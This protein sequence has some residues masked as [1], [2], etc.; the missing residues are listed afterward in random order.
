GEAE[1]KHTLRDALPICAERFARKWRFKVRA[2]RRTG[3]DRDIP[4]TRAVWEP[5]LDAQERRYRRRECVSD[6]DLRLVRKE[7][8]VFRD[9]PADRKSTRL[10]SS[11]VS[12]P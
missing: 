11:H 3:W 5:L 10:N 12:I 1:P 6:E 8:A 7:L 9:P 4:V 2:R